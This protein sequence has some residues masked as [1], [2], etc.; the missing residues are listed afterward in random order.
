MKEVVLWRQLAIIV[1][2]MIQDRRTEDGL[3]VTKASEAH[4][5][6]WLTCKR[7]DT[8]HSSVI[9]NLCVQEDDSLLGYEEVNPS[10]LVPSSLFDF[11]RLGSEHISS[12]HNTHSQ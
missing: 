5:N 4:L 10:A 8:V 6:P 3:K 2:Q 11:L 7:I 12:T 9:P 1:D